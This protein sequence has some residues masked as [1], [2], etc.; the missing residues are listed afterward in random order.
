MLAHIPV[1]V[2]AVLLLLLYLGHRQAQARVVRPAVLVA[3]AVA[4]CG[5]SLYGV[6]SAFGVVPVALLPWLAGYALSAIGGSRLVSRQGMAVVD[7]AVR[8]PGSWVP[9]ALMLGI[10]TARF[11]LGFAAAVRPSLVHDPVLVAALS[12]ALGALSGGFGARALAVRR[13]ARRGGARDAVA[14]A[15]C[16]AGAG[17]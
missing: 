7:A 14:A 12:A 2:P 5:L 17:P 10:F 3:V 4:M 9:L 6:V 15:G 8:V 1:W 13:F 16:P 11:A